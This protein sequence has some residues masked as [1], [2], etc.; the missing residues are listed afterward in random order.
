MIPCAIESRF[1]YFQWINVFDIF[2]YNHYKKEKKTNWKDYE[3]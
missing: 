3:L 1:F 2:C